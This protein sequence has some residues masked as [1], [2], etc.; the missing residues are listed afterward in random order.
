MAKN[1]ELPWG[2]EVAYG[3]IVSV[4]DAGLVH[5]DLIHGAFKTINSGG[6][7]SEEDVAAIDKSYQHFLGLRAH[8]AETHKWAMSEADSPEG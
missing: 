2:T 7:V 6:R 3:S 4:M 8:Q 5:L 1:I